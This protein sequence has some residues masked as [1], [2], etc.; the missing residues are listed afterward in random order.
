MNLYLDENQEEQ[1]EQ[2]TKFDQYCSQCKE[3]LLIC[4]I[5]VFP[6][7]NWIQ[8]Y[9]WK[10]DLLGDFVSGFTVAIMHIPHGL[11]YATLANVSPI[12][13]IYM[14]IFPVIFYALFSTSRHISV[15]TFAVI[16]LMTGEVV[17]DNLKINVSRTN[18]TSDYN[19]IEIATAVS[20]TVGL[21]HI[22]MFCLR[23]GIVC[24]VFSGTFISSFTCGASIH[25]L[26]SQIKELLGIKI[27]PHYGKFGLF[28]QYED[29]ILNVPK[30][31]I[32]TFAMSSASIAFLSVCKFL[33]VPLLQK[34]VKI[35]LPFELIVILIANTFSTSLHLQ[36]HGINIVGDIPRGFPSI[37][38][39]PLSLVTNVIEAS[40]FITVVSY[41][42]SMS[43]A[44]MFATTMN[45]DI[46]GTQELL[47]YGL[48]NIIGSFLQCLPVSSSLSR[49][50][51]QLVAGGKSQIASIFSCMLLSVI[52]L[53]IA[54]FFE[55]LPKCVL[56]A[57]ITISLTQMYFQ[58]KNLP[59]IWKLSKLE[60]L[61]WVFTFLSV[62]VLDVKSG[63]IIGVAL[64]LTLVFIESMRPD[65]KLLGVIKIPVNSE[66]DN[67]YEQ[68]FVDIKNKHATEINGVKI[69]YV[70]ERLTFATKDHIKNQIFTVSGVNPQ[71]VLTMK[72]RMERRKC[73]PEDIEDMEERMRTVSFKLKDSE[74]TDED[75]G[76]TIKKSKLNFIIIDMKSI[77]HLDGSGINLIEKIVKYY[78][79][80]NI[81]VCIISNYKQ[82]SSL[83]SI[84]ILLRSIFHENE[85]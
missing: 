37:K 58:I 22:F 61:V 4:A 73:P 50:T 3:R 36:Q 51:I 40:F 23:F 82:F 78:K 21:W 35:R 18:M 14:A 64:T 34:R 46:D 12:H 33:I 53:W 71:E 19:A 55:T 41:S 69:I 83:E 56:A 27:N 28:Y 8:E 20:F 45:Y 31:N 7:L 65:V 62:I 74:S 75:I 1:P 63:L 79:E 32:N 66:D 76:I 85:I 15:G 77:K 42:V 49:S 29:I 2:T 57:V 47:A 25:V 54:P 17:N 9:Q 67:S 10:T 70:S 6:F 13:G 11:A 16:C 60:S 43:M 68:V 24:S 26:T 5:T 59:Q 84:D 80:I 48:A 52:I 30:T 39:P 38:P 81:T 72:R 44:T